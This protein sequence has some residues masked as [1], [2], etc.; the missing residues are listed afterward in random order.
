MKTIRCAICWTDRH[1]LDVY[2]TRADS[3][4]WYCNNKKA[5]AKRAKEARK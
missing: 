2:R 1:P 3:D 5:C 4:V